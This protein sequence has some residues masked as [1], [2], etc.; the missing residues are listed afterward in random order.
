M[1]IDQPPDTSEEVDERIGKVGICS[2]GTYVPPESEG[3]SG[4]CVAPRRDASIRH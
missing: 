4:K 3:E 1:L 2:A